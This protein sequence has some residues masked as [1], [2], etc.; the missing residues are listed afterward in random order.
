MDVFLPTAVEVRRPKFPLGPDLNGGA[1]RYGSWRSSA[2]SVNAIGWRRLNGFLTRSEPLH[3]FQYTPTELRAWR[4]PM[5]KLS[6]IL[7]QIMLGLAAT[8]LQ[9]LDREL[10][11]RIDHSRLVP[12][13]PASR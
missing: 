7:T 12:S 1:K 11:L 9:M 10:A 6:W 2:D 5:S 4:L 13:V 3:I 8:V